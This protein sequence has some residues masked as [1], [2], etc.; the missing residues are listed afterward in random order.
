MSQVVALGVKL[1]RALQRTLQDAEQFRHDLFPPIHSRC[2]SGPRE[3]S[4]RSFELVQ[5]L[6]YFHVIPI[7]L[8]SG[9]PPVPALSTGNAGKTYLGV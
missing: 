8:L 6:G 3:P 2:H 4:G 1:H 7:V 9:T 5:D